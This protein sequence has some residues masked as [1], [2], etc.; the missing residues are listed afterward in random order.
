[1][2][3]TESVAVMDALILLKEEMRNNEIENQINAIHRLKTVILSIGANKMNTELVPY[4]QEL[5]QEEDDELLYAIAEELGV[6]GGLCQDKTTFLPL[7][8]SLAKQDETVVREEAIKSLTKICNQLNEREVNS[9]FCPM[10]LRLASE[11][12]FTGRMSACQLF[13]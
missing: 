5:I 3:N 8:E 4:L 10:I 9:Y 12:W 1:M 7:L 2:P 6:T 13:C 11:E